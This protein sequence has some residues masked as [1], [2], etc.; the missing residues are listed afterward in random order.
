MDIPHEHKRFIVINE[1]VNTTDF[2]D[3][4]DMTLREIIQLRQKHKD[5]ENVANYIG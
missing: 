1:V 2:E 5:T 3:I 4:E